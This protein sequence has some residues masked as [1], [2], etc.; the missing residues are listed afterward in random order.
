[1]TTKNKSILPKRE[2]V[3]L[4][5]LAKELGVNKSKL[6]Y[7]VK[8]GLFHPVTDMNKISKI[9]IYDKQEILNSLKIIEKLKAKGCSLK[10]ITTKKS[11]KNML[12]TAK[13]I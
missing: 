3:T 2:L 4:A 12:L 13:N 9:G 11:I 6:T 5:L 8:L 7:Y 1:M 10:D